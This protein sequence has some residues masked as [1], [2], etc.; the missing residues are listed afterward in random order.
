MNLDNEKALDWPRVGAVKSHVNI[1][2]LMKQKIGRRR[3]GRPRKALLRCGP[4]RRRARR[5]EA[6]RDGQAVRKHVFQDSDLR[7][8]LQGK[9]NVIELQ[10]VLASQT[11]K[12]SISSYMT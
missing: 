8:R 5:T 4:A 12:L 6:V 1:T 11:G 3:P 7:R 9:T 2:E 10:K